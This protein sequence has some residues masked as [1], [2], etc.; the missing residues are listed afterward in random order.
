[1]GKASEKK[2]SEDE[3]RFV[4]CGEQSQHLVHEDG[5]FL[6]SGVW[7]GDQGFTTLEVVH[8][9]QAGQAVS[10]DVV[11]VRSRRRRD[12]IQELGCNLLWE[13]SYTVIEFGHRAHDPLQV[14]LGVSVGEPRHRSLGPEG[15]KFDA[16]GSDRFSGR[17]GDIDVV[18]GSGAEVRD[19]GRL[20]RLRHSTAE[21]KKIA[22]AMKTL[23]NGTVSNL[24]KARL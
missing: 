14:E 5:G 13:G 8:G 6:V 2:T 1:M 24:L 10:E 9:V 3:V 4:A 23:T 18:G 20:L 15:G 17:D 7:Q 12:Q 16:N 22:W 19:G 21:I 11:W